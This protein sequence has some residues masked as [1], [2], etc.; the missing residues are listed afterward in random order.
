MTADPVAFDP[1]RIFEALNRHG[2]EYLVIGGFA[3]VTHG[4]VRATRD[5]DVVTAQR[6]ENAE[7]LAAALRELGA[8]VRGVD[9][10]HLPVDPT[11]AD[12]LADGASWTLTTEGGWLDLM[13]D[14]PGAAPFDRLRARSVTASVRG[15][16]IPVVGLDDLVRMKRA[17]GR[18]RDLADV[19]A[20]TAP[21]D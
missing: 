7:R 19:A 21:L 1:L 9:A 16:R 6:R 11:D 3:V 4:H 15:V 20:L 14:P 8:R 12:D 10:E 13:A 18:P 5:I 2:V 17:S